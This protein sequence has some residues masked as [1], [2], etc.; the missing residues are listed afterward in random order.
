MK[1]ISFSLLILCIHIATAQDQDPNNCI[2]NVSTNYEHPTNDALPTYSPNY[3][4]NG[5]NWVPKNPYN[6][7]YVNYDCSNMFFAGVEIPEMNNIM[8]SN[9]TYY[10]YLSDGPLPLNENGW[11]LLLVNLGRYPDDIKEV[12]DNEM[13]ALPYIVIYN[14]Y[15]GLMR[16]FFQFG[17][18]HT[19]GG[20]ADAV[21][22]MVSFREENEMS[23]L[24]RLNEGLDQGLNVKSDVQ[25]VRSHAKAP[26]QGSQWA[27]TDFQLA[28]DPCTCFYPSNLKINFFQTRSSTIALQGRSITL[29]DEALIE[30]SILQTNP[31]RFLSGYDFNDEFEKANGGGLVM[32]KSLEKMIENYRENYKKYNAELIA[33]GEHNA[34][35]KKNLALLEMGLF[36]TRIIANPPP[37][38]VTLT[39]E[40]LAE[41]AFDESYSEY[42]GL[43]QSEIDQKY[44]NVGI[45]N[46]GGWFGVVEKF[47]KEIVK[48]NS[49]GMKSI[50]QKALFNTIGQLFGE[51]G[52]TFVEQNFVVKNPPKE[53]TMPTATFSEMT[54]KGT[55][56]DHL[57]LG[58]PEFYTPGTYGSEGTGSPVLTKVSEYPVYNEILGQFALLKNPKIKII[59]NTVNYSHNQEIN[60]TSYTTGYYDV[61]IYKHQN[62]TTEYQIMLDEE[63]LY[64][65]NPALD[66]TDYTISAAFEIIATPKVRDNQ[67]G[68]PTPNNVIFNTFIAPSSFVNL[69][70]DNYDLSSNTPIITN[71][72][73]FNYY[74]SPIFNSNAF[75]DELALPVTEHLEEQTNERL[76]SFHLISEH[77][78]INAFKPFRVAAGIHHQ[79]A[80]LGHNFIHA[81]ELDQYD[82][83]VDANGAIIWDLEDP[84]LIKPKHLTVGFHGYEFDFKINLKLLVTMDF[85]TLNSKGEANSVTQLLTYEVDPEDITYTNIGAI[86]NLY[87]TDANISQFEKDLFFGNQVV[88]VGQPYNYNFSG[89]AVDGCTLSGNTY[90]CRA[91]NDITILGEIE[92]TAPYKVNFYAGNEIQ[93]IGESILPH[94]ANLEIKPVLD[95]SIPNPKAKVEDIYDF[96]MGTNGNA[97]SYQAN[98]AEGKF[99]QADSSDAI[100]DNEIQPFTEDW[101]FSLYPNPTHNSTTVQLFDVGAYEVSIECFD[102]MMSKMN[103]SGEQIDSGKIKI[104][105]EHL[106]AGIYIIKVS[107]NG[108]FKSKR[109]IIQ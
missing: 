12:E 34:K 32:H 51:K 50:N 106:S 19:V 86:D 2:H 44:L 109:L 49:A 40:Q 69:S 56:I 38:I 94:T 52:K 22:V 64:A 5:F 92:I 54:Y 27:S 70:S 25:Y 91:W 59:E 41:R 33:V 13:A 45:Q 107:T 81:A 108:G 9:L 31:T 57:D 100:N 7:L 63:L 11:E 6:Q 30:N 98:L 73:S 39:E 89:Q 62:W 14:R 24:L 78:P 43:S 58:G 37:G 42:V 74:N 46:A 101:D 90:T 96:C 36:V 95:Y 68:D 3:Y 21:E 102:I 48:A 99:G 8:V 66:M 97:P 47:Y 88:N 79:T 26:A 61:D 105:T 16:V 84:D 29:P 23:G 67:L 87:Y 65:L 53:P 35:V 77:L 4:L 71:E 93:V 76:R 15:T 85:E 1:L 17:L 82:H 10:N 75:A 28:Y 18:D 83:L 72:Q 104:P 60:T 55:I 103:I 80:S 20:G